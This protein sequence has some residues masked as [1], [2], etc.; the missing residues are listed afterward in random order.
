MR[1][2][3][4]DRED[5]AKPVVRPTRVFADRR[6][7]QPHP[8]HRAA[9]RSARDLVQRPAHELDRGAGGDEHRIRFGSSHFQHLRPGCRQRQGHGSR[10]V[11]Q[12]PR[13]RPDRSRPGTSPSL[14]RAARG[15]AEAPRAGRQAGGNCRC[16]PRRGRP[17]A[18]EPRQSPTRPGWNSSSVAAAMASCTGWT[19]NGLIAMRAT[20]RSRLAPSAVAPSAMGSRWNRWLATQIRLQPARSATFTL[21]RNAA[22][23]SRPSEAMLSSDKASYRFENSLTG[24][25]ARCQCSSAIRNRRRSRG[26]CPRP[27]ARRTRARSRASPGR[28][29]CP[30]PAP[31]CSTE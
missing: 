4:R 11:G 28:P 24:S 14:P 19:V 20:R 13:A 12:L 21:P 7:D 10:A 18:P 15:R 3:Q 16:R 9:A 8:A 2:T 25:A 30:A 27:A 31:P 1:T 29:P 5:A 22:G 6:I 23:A 17:G 26:S